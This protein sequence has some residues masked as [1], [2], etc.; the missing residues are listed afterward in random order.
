MASSEPLPSDVDACHALIV[1]KNVAIAQKDEVIE[2]L[3]S[4]YQTLRENYELLKRFAYGQ[5][6]ERHVPEDDSELKLFDSEQD[7]APKSPEPATRRLSVKPRFHVCR[8]WL[9][10][11]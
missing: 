10:I 3:S 9:M 5:R 7:T 8:T 4:D 11:G 6:S 2:T 1:Q